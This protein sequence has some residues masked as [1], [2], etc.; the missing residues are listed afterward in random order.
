[1][2]RNWFSLTS[3]TNFQLIKLENRNLNYCLFIL[4]SYI[5]NPT[6]TTSRIEYPELRRKS[7]DAYAIIA[8]L[9]VIFCI[10]NMAARKLNS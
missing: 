4:S 10:L 7:P 8:V 1:M 3:N 2:V 5:R 9:E 6:C